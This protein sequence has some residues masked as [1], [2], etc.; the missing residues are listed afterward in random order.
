MLT[1]ERMEPLNKWMI[2]TIP[3]CWP[4]VKIFVNQNFFRPKNLLNQNFS[5]LLFR[6]EIFLDPNNLGHNILFYP[7]SFYPIFW[8]KEIYGPHFHGSARNHLENG[9]WVD[10]WVGRWVST[11]TQ[12]LCL[13]D[14][15]YNCLIHLQDNCCTVTVSILEHDL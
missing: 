1:G 11:S 4:H 15:A 13:N 2:L 5:T 9:I 8:T 12:E 6:T 14:Q 3:G 10:C 7:N